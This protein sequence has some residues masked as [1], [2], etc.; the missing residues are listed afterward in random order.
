MRYGCLGLWQHRLVVGVQDRR[1]LFSSW[2]LRRE[3]EET[4]V[5][6]F[7][8]RAWLQGLSFL[9]HDTTL[10]QVCSFLPV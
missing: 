9:T 3:R 1:G 2:Q 10:E 6:V 8:S 5:P 7:L 4:R